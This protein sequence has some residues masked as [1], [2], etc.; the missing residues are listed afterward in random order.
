MVVL[1]KLD[2]CV[3][4]EACLTAVRAVA[5]SAPMVAISARTSVEPLL[6]HLG[7]GRTIAL[8][9]SSG[10]GK[11]TIVNGLLGEERLSTGDVRESDSRGRHT[12]VYARN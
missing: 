8:L 2:L 4:V 11:S 6:P 3:E 9:G 7:M 5:G 1:N 10:A 12:S